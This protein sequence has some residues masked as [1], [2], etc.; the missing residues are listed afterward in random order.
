MTDNRFSYWILSLSL[1]MI[2]QILGNKIDGLRNVGI[3]FAILLALTLYWDYESK[4]NQKR[5]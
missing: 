1:S 2:T 3:V 5:K 4:P